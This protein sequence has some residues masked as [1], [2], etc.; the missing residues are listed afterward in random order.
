MDDKAQRSKEVNSQEKATIDTIPEASSS[1]SPLI[2]AKQEQLHQQSIGGGD[3]GESLIM[4][5]L[6]RSYLS[7]ITVSVQ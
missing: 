1:S 7:D 5:C 6:R 4:H 2:K 3:L